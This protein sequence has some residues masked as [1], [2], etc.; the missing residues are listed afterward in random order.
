MPYS[1]AK[2]ILALHSPLG[3]DALALVRIHGEERLSG[4]FRFELDLL[5]EERAIDFLPSSARASPR[6]SASPAAARA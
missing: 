6:S 5:S 4:L 1:Q 3:P 2:T